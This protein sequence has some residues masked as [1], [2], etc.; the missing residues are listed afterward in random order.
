MLIMAVA[1]LESLEQVSE[2]CFSLW[3]DL[4]DP[5][6]ASASDYHVF[7]QLLVSA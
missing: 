4:Y 1:D 6:T 5:M 2:L 7:C 3:G